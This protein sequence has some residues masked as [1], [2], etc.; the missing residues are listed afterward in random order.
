MR[1]SIFIFSFFLSVTTATAQ[2]ITIDRLRNKLAS[3]TSDTAKCKILDSLSMYNMFFTSRLDSTVNYC[4]ENVNTAFS[5][6]DKRYLILAYAR[7]GFYYTNVALFKECLDVTFKGLDL[8]EKYHVSDYLSALY[9]DLGWFYISVGNSR[10]A[11]APALKGVAFLKFSKDPFFDQALHLYGMLGSIYQDMNKPDSMLYYFH[12]MDSSAAVS[13]ER[14]ARVISDYYWG[15]YYLWGEKNYQKADSVS[16]AAIVE[17]R[18]YD[19]FL[20]SGFYLYLAYSS[21][22]QNHI[23]KAISETKEAFLLSSAV[24]DRSSR[25]AAA[26]LLSACYGKSGKLDS[27]YYYLKMKDSLNTVIQ[28]HSD[29]TAIQQFE[30]DGQIARKEQSAAT[31][32]R[33]QKNRSRILTYVFVMAVF[34]FLVIALIQWWNSRQRKKANIVLQQ[35]KQK[36]E[37]TL[38]ELKSTQ[39]QLIQSEKMASLGE[40]TAGIAHEIQNPLNFVNNF[41]EVNKELSDDLDRGSRKRGYRRE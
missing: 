19:H 10:E 11:L 35:E 16:L 41:S 30:F 36:V 2:N 31:V 6:P 15:E 23:D 21:L 8:S 18:K 9:Y 29:G 26:D 27:A 13:T 22:S 4:N 5:I 17:C 38:Q 37:S 32:L 40:L 14:G 39:A 33:D 24:S 12:K 28:Q 3:A 20:L 1:R 34:F 25:M 7:L